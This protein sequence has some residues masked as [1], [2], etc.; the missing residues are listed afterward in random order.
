[1]KDING[2]AYLTVEQALTGVEIEVDGDFTCINVGEKRKL[3][4]SEYGLYFECSDGC[5]DLVGQLSNDETH[6][7]GLYPTKNEK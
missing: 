7:I 4:E 3:T 2:R 5:H 1:M 6:Y